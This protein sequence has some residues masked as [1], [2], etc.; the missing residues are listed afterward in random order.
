MITELKPNQIFVFGS[1]EAGR[2]GRGAAKQALDHFGAVYGVGE[3]LTG[4]SYAFPTLDG[5]IQ[6][7]PLTVR[8]TKLSTSRD[9][10]YETCRQH[11][12]LEFLLTEVG[13]GLAGY[14]EDYMKSFFTNVPA[15]LILPEG[16]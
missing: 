10:L 13:C 6:Q 1:N 11:P 15:N 16:W 2:S 8:S 14:S 7:F 4:Q 12:E 3:G 5:N 9:K